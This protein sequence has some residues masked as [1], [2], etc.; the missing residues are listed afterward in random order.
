[1]KPYPCIKAGWTGQ[2]EASEVACLFGFVTGRVS[3]EPGAKHLWS[4][5]I[6]FLL[7]R[8]EI[9]WL[10]GIVRYPLQETL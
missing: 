5:R 10:T 4:L 8:V 3:Y 9:N 6:F 1:M 7:W 2:R